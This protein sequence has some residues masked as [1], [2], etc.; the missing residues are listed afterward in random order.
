[1]TRPLAARPQPQPHPQDP[2]AV[3]GLRAARR[4]LVRYYRN[5]DSI[6]AAVWRDEEGLWELC[7]PTYE[8]QFYR[9]YLYATAPRALLRKADRCLPPFVEPGEWR[10]VPQ[11][12]GEYAHDHHGMAPRRTNPYGHRES[13]PRGRLLR[14][15]RQQALADHRHERLSGEA[16]DAADERMGLGEAKGALTLAAEALEALAAELRALAGHACEYDA[17]DYCRHCGVDGRA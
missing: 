6:W 2:D 13:G 8:G 10:E 5:G 11:E 4:R 9:H 17:R 1:M 15:L 16:L 3:R 12:A 7:N 14:L